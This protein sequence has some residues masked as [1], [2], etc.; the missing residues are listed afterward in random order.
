MRAG[1]ILIRTREK[2]SSVIPATETSAR[3]GDA[4][5]IVRLYN[6]P[7]FLFRTV[8][9]Y[10]REGLER[11]EG[12]ILIARAEHR[13][14]FERSLDALGCD[15]GVARARGQLVEHDAAETLNR[16]VIG[17]L[18]RG[19]PD[20]DAF[21]AIL[22]E[23]VDR[24]RGRHAEVRA[25]G[26]MV[27]I[28]L[29][30]GNAVG[31]T[32]LEELWCELIAGSPIQL[33]CAYQLSRFDHPRHRDTLRTICRRHTHVLPAE[34]FDEGLDSEEQRRRIA[35]L[36]QAAAAL[37]AEVDER[38]HIEEALR[39]REQELSDFIE[40]ASVGMHWI[41]ADG[42]ILWANQAE[43]SLLGYA[44]EEYIGHDIREFHADSE[45]IESLLER[46]V[47]SERIRD[48]EA[49]M[50]A[51]NGALKHVLINSSVYWEDGRFV[52]TRC[53]LRDITERKLLDV[54]LREERERLREER[55]R[56]R[57]A[58]RRKDEF[59]AMLSHELRNPLAPILTAL[60]LMDLRGQAETRQE[61]EMIRRQ[62]RHLAGLIE[63]LLDISRVS[64]GKIRIR[65]E[66]TELYPLVERAI[67]MAAP[68]FEQRVHTLVFDV[69]KSGLL[70]DADPIR[71]PQVFANLL[72]N[73][74]K[75]TSPGGRICVVARREAEEIVAYVEDNGIGIAPEMLG[76]MF[77]PFVQG[78]RTI[79]RS[80]GGLGLGLALVRSLTLLHGGSVSAHSDGPGKGSRLLIRL[81]GRA[82]SDPAPDGPKR[83]T[84]NGARREPE[85]P[86]RVLVV[87]DNVD[88][89]VAF[90]EV[91]RRLGHVVEVAYNGPQALAI[92]R[93]FRPTTALVDI[94]LPSMDG[95]E[96]ARR[97]REE[98]NGNGLRLVAVTG[99]GE[100]NDR[101]KSREAGFDL[102]TVKPVD[103]DGL[104]SL[105]ES[106]L[107]P[108]HE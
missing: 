107:T 82:T 83:A 98:A 45:V 67:E 42:T 44:R 37:E 108:A 78:R 62:A 41:A 74:A 105:L 102:H 90:A 6:S 15:L 3:R 91:V 63:D 39:R 18:Q 48:F 16:I 38:R 80:Q 88:C 101:T 79:D 87:D 97:L 33:Y 84:T 40:T 68:L 21:R 95:Y 94:G 103:L 9:E 1:K 76:S 27:D 26:E 20:P 22:G 81:P 99:Y 65:K 8:S 34:S 66:R 52:H 53:F 60:D 49:R 17:G 86:E 100:E 58:N 71:L 73:A 35:E 11:G 14:G 12:I 92:A 93:M 61:R 77:E 64:S 50:V 23:S 56:L 29:H 24:M 36:Q 85:N 31:T 2:E 30:L 70:V 5:H 13:A 19:L 72:T 59:L 25:Y 43:M 55:E 46:L 104:R 32:Q 54:A 69:P 10:I 75:Y 57:E 4:A 28:L 47:R 106:G 89:A 96:L 51:K 7:E